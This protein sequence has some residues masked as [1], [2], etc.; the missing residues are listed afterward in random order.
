M[1]SKSTL[2]CIKYDNSEARKRPLHFIPQNFILWWMKSVISWTARFYC[3]YEKWGR[4]TCEII[5][6]CFCLRNL[7]WNGK[8][9]I[10][11]S[12]F[13][14]LSSCLSYLSGHLS[15]WPSELQLWR[16]IYLSNIKHC[17][18]LCAKLLSLIII[19]LITHW[20]LIL[21]KVNFMKKCLLKFK[22]EFLPYSFEKHDKYLL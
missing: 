5:Y 11:K 21:A 8:C 19:S 7:P 1:C 9:S 16:K 2:M 18:T 3:K 17:N 15:T 6:M 14:L 10:E 22:Y 4:L 13:N 20:A 12:A